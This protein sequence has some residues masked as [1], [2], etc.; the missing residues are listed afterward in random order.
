ML[1]PDQTR[2]AGI[3]CRQRETCERH[4]QLGRDEMAPKGTL[5][6]VYTADT[7]RSVPGGVCGWRIRPESAD[8]A[9][10]GATV[11]TR[12]GNAPSAPEGEPRCR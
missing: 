10:S 1:A 3:G 11:A 5:G 2:C 6:T 9:S 4:R 8:R 12:A 7:L